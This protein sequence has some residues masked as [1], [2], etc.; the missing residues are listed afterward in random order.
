M[1]DE[2]ETYEV[3]WMRLMGYLDAV[4]RTAQAMNKNNQLPDWLYKNV[5]NRVCEME[6]DLQL[7]KEVKER[8]G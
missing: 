7:N 8:E 2:D 3:H 5:N 4:V 6:R 1:S